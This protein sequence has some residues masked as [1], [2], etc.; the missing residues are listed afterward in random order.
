MIPLLKESDLCRDDT[1]WSYFIAGPIQTLDDFAQRIRYQSQAV[2]NGPVVRLLRGR[3]CAAVETTLQEWSAALQFPYYCAYTSFDSFDDCITDLSW[4]PG[5]CYLFFWTDIDLVLPGLEGDLRALVACLKRAHDAWKIPNRW[6]T[7]WPSAP[8][9]VIFHAELDMGD[10]A[11]QR[12]RA[13]GAD[14][15]FV[16]FSDEILTWRQRFNQ[17]H[18]IEQN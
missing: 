8:F 1:P 9:T 4:L 10:L 13:V 3:R 16:R 15:V 18:P 12:L 2:L 11:M 6:N 7:D 17:A 14:P 5:S